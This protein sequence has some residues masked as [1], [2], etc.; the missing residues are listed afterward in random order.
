MA[1]KMISLGK[2]SDLHTKRQVYAYITKDD[3]AKKLFDE[4]QNCH[5]SCVAAASRCV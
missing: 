2:A 3:V 4:L 5:L 1:E